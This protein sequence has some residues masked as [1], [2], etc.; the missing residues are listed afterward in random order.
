MRNFLLIL[1]GLVIVTLLSGHA[2]FAQGTTDLALLKSAARPATATRAS[3]RHLT[4]WRC[5]S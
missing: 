4:D 5:G 1:T 2:A 3:P